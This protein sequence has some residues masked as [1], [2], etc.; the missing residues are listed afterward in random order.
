MEINKIAKEI[1]R[2]NS[3]ELDELS[4]ALLEYNISATMYRFGGT[5]VEESREFDVFMSDA[6]NTKLMVV[7]TVKEL[8]DLGLRDAKYIVDSAP[9]MIKEFTSYENALL[10]RNALVDAGATIELKP[11][12]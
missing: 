1:A 11:I 3:I 8:L 2:L 6:G 4:S 12:G 5:P 7:K 10:L 9:C